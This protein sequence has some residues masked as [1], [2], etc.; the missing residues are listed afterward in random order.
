MTQ[1][2]IGRLLGDSAAE[3]FAAEV[4]PELLARVDEGH[5]PQGL[6][7]VLEGSEYPQLFAAGDDE[8]TWADAYPLVLAAGHALAPV[9]LPETLLASWLAQRVGLALGP[10]IATVVPQRVQERWT[11]T[12]VGGAWRVSGAAH[13]VP[14]AARAA[15]VVAI[16]HS[17]SGPVVAA[18]PTAALTIAPDRNAAA[19]PRDAIVADAASAEAAPLGALPA[20]VVQRFG[21]LLRAA[22]IAGALRG[23]LALAGA[24]SKE[25]QQ[26]GRPIGQFQAISQ[27]LAV[28]AEEA[29]AAEV[30]A[31]A[32]WRAAAADPATPVIPIAKVR[33][34]KAAGIAP[35]I[36]HAVFGAIGITAEHQLHFAS[37]RLW[38]WRAEFGDETDWARELGR[39][40]VRAGGARLWPSVVEAREIGTATP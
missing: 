29:A 9:P 39:A 36:A 8:I 16:A 33:T 7:D 32:G 30:A 3:L 17:P 24:Y 31:A 22:Q 1:S 6:W 10:G 13:G 27:Q 18:L 28:L 5:W 2:D 38:S 15:R 4:T 12:S 34:G 25:R 37:R 40:V 11:A 26:F 23:V 21:A 35:A 14:W 20:D 19:E